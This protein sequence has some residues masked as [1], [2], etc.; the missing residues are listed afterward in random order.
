MRL[1]K[2]YGII[3]DTIEASEAKLLHSKTAAAIAKDLFGVSDA[4]HDAILWHTTGRMDM[5]LLEKVIYLA[6]YIEPTRHFDG[7]ERLRQLAYTDLNLALE[8]GFQMSIEDMQERG[9]IPHERTMQAWQW[10]VTTMRSE[11]EER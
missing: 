5:T 6:D 10:L 8:L 7:V 11:K 3:N 4:V 1:C 9:I 2:E